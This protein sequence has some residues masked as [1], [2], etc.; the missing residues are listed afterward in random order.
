[1]AGGHSEAI[2]LSL[3]VSPCTTTEAPTHED[4]AVIVAGVRVPAGR[5]RF[6]ASTL[7]SPGTLNLTS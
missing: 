3:F 5:R 4:D 7:A 6:N 2:P 1:M